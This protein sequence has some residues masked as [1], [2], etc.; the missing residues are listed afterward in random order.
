MNSDERVCINKTRFLLNIK[1][2]DW[3]VHINVPTWGKCTA[4]KV[5]G[6]YTFEKNDNQFGDFRH[7]IPVDT[8]TLITFDR[9][10]QN[11]LPEIS[12]K[13]KLRGRYWRIYATNE[14]LTSIE[15]L[16]NN[17]ISIPDNASHGLF[18]LKEGL[19]KYLPQ[20]TEIIQKNH[21]KKNLEEFIAFIFS[22]LPNTEVKINGSGYGTDNGADIIVN[23]TTGLPICNLQKEETLVIQVKSF[24]GTHTD[25]TAV[26]Q[27]KEAINHYNADVGLILSTAKPSDELLDKIEEAKA[28]IEK[29]I[30]LIAGDDV[31]NFV[32]KYGSEYLFDI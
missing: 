5:K 15:N 4:A 8:E 18:Y 7:T 25:S 10:N 28:E 16:K 22:K 19:K 3:I 27:I 31:A 26:T 2:E 21:P 20:I 1:P 12:N 30:V 6:A 13:L 14:F 9:N 32:L 11:V 23:Y 17:S 29:P 24:I